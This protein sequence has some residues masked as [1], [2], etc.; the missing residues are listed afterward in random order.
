LVEGR[1]AQQLKAQFSRGFH[2]LAGYFACGVDVLG[3]DGFDEPG[4]LLE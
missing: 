3:F 4:V 1:L 2:V